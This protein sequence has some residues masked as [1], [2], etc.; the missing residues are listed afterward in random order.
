MRV[1]R[2]RNSR[3][4]VV[5]GRRVTVADRWWRRAFGLMG[6]RHLAPGE[7]LLLEPCSSV[8]TLGMRFPIC[9]QRWS[10]PQAF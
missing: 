2:A 6:R 1:V 5:V 10:S 3:S 4:G 9:K 7:G 8:H